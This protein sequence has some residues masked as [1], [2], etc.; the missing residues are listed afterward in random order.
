MEV[1]WERISCTTLEID[2]VNISPVAWSICGVKCL[3]K[4]HMKHSRSFIA[5][6]IPTSEEAKQG[7]RY[8]T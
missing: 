1:L 2:F 5:S 6:F 4:T 3:F 8:W 7:P